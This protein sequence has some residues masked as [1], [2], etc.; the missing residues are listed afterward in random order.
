MR[1]ETA[2][3]ILEKI[4][5]K[6]REMDFIA[7]HKTD[8]NAF[9]RKRKLS[10]LDIIFFVIGKTGTTLDFEVEKLQEEIGTGVTSAAVSKSRDKVSYTAFKALF[11]ETAQDIPVT[12][13]FKGYKVTSFDGLQGELP[14][15]AELMAKYKVSNTR[16]YPQFHALAQ[17]DV[18]NSCYTNA[19]FA[20]AP[21]DERKLVCELLEEHNYDGNEIFLLDRGF[22]SIKLIQALEKKGKKYVMRVSKSFL[23]EVNDFSKT[24]SKDKQIHIDYDEKRRG[25]SRINSAELPYSFDIRCVKI[26]LPKGKQE[27]LITNLWK[28][29]F[30]R[31]EIGELYNLR[32]K[33]ETA[34]L[35]LKYAVHVEEFMGKK[36]NSIKQEFYATLI[37]A[38]LAMIFAEMA[39]KMIVLKKRNRS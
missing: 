34:F 16:E 37:Q 39:S 33:I 17:Y 6:S 12:N 8:G 25:V 10:F 2:K 9:I 3:R 35:H 14:K 7:K 20:P 26:G 29:E 27:V 5:K 23:K 11:C 19:V 36:E 21:A 22:P 32:W 28:N 31:T 1:V 4:A 30:S 38:N 13:N 18:L 24:K 15:T